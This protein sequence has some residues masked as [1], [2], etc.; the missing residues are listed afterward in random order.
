MPDHE[1]KLIHACQPVEQRNLWW[2]LILS[3]L[4][5]IAEL[6]GGYLSDSLALLADASHMF[7]D[8]AAIGLSLFAIWISQKP[9]D[10]RRTYG[11]HR[12]EILIALING[13]V[14]IAIALGIFI[15]ALERIQNPVSIRANLMLWVATGGL[16]VNCIGLWLTREGKRRSLNM[17]AVWLHILSDLVGSV[18]AV[19]A[20]ISI[21][22]W[23]SHIVDPWVSILM[24]GLILYGAWKLVIESV[25]VLLESVPEG[26]NIIEL[27]DRLRQVTGVE[28]IHDLHVWLLSSGIPTL[29]AH[30]KLTPTADSAKVLKLL[31]E[32]LNQ[33]YQIDHVTLQLEP[34]SYE[35]QTM[36]V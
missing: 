21:V 4:Y 24:S 19:A 8:I 13:A 27:R 26:L 35:H 1:N 30:V 10:E 12:A 31:T 6:V 25:N 34:P 14:L 23:N 9:A 32:L 5:F 15:K 28:D 29:S 17:R 33:C 20:A 11:Y 36:H 16:I 7:I 3:F 18:S 2:V 22:L